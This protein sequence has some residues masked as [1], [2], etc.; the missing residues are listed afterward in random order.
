LSG[1]VLDEQEEMMRFQERSIRK[2]EV[3]FAQSKRSFLVATIVSHQ[4]T[5]ARF[6]RH[7]RNRFLFVKRFDWKW[8]EFLDSDDAP[9][10]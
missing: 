7:A 10:R 4:Q 3:R 9:Y 5:M 8:R 2:R 1:P 6:P